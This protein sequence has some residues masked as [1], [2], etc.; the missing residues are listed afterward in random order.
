MK[1]INILT[2]IL[3]PLFILLFTGCEEE[4][5]APGSDVNH[6]YVTTS[7]GTKT[8]RTQINNRVNL[9]DFSKGVKS[10]VWT[11]GDNVV[12]LEYNA[13]STSTEEY[14]KIRFTTP[15]QHNVTLSQVFKGN[16]WVGDELMDVATY[17]TTITITVVDSIRAN[18][19]AV[20]TLDG[21][22]LTNANEALNVLEGGREMTF[23]DLSTG[24]PEKLR[25]IFSRPDGYIK[26]V[27]GTP[28]TTKLNSVGNYDMML[29]ASSAFGVDTI[30][31][32]N[33]IKIIP[34]T[35]PMVLESITAD[36]QIKLT[37]SR[38]VEYPGGCD[39][40][41]FTLTATNEGKDI[42][43]TIK[44]INLDPVYSNIVIIELNEEIYNTD[45][46]IIS[47]DNSIGNLISSDGMVIDSFTDRSVVFSSR[48]DIFSTIG[49]GSIENSTN[50]NWA[51]AWW[52]G[53]WGLYNKD[54]N[55]TTAMAYEGAQSLYFNI[56]AYTEIDAS[57]K[58]AGGALN[59][60]DADG[61]KKNVLSV[62]AGKTYEGSMWVYIE[63]MGNANT[64]DGL[65]PNLLWMRTDTW[66]VLFGAQFY[67]GEPV[68]SW[69]KTKIRFV[70]TKTEDIPFII[71]LY[72]G[73]STVAHK[74]YVDNIKFEE[75]EVRP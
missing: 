33:Y 24:E 63:Q 14:P 52:G 5:E 3:L 8:N 68:G 51:Y 13:I 50:Y 19:S 45:E 22:L 27:L 4:Y 23:T 40:T 67:G 25:W 2:G 48:V 20:R 31:Y 30:S 65:N 39:P 35:D 9:I 69:Y 16:V 60:R 41:S 54:N 43:L 38:D 21:S 29:I 15:G 28:A 64:G 46:I 56:D 75:I 74:F 58:G 47:Y 10:R 49:D 73:S 11:F 61:N 59:Y 34:S 37:Y 42:P 66:A 26:E 36:K 57:N 6:V 62:E 7:F 18:F 17:D 70:S 1:R 72:N 32:K 53:V 71:R 12:D 55:V 44:G